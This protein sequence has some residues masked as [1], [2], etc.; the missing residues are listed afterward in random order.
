MIELLVGLIKLPF[1]LVGV[2]LTFVFGLVGFILSILG[3]VLTPLLGVG[4]IILPFGLAFLLL[5]GLIGALL[6]PRHT[7]IV[8][9]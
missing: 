2:V 5:A 8:Y 3:V 7:T 9:R 6:K 1:L 4:L